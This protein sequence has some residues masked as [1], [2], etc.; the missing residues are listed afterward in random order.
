MKVKELLKEGSLSRHFKLGVDAGN[1]TV[2]DLKAI[3]ANGGF[4]GPTAKRMC[5]LIS[6]KPDIY[7]ITLSVDAWKNSTVNGT[8]NISSGKLF[9]GDICYCFSSGESSDENWEPFLKKTDYLNKYTDS[10][11][12]NKFLT[13]DTGGDGTC[14]VYVGMAPLRDLGE[15]DK[16]QKEKEKTLDRLDAVKAQLEDAVRGIKELEDY[17]AELDKKIIDLQGE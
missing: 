12:K 15:I 2:A 8:I 14:G 6:I 1:I 11:V 3:E 7:K 13:A 17:V 5:Q 16:L 4:F 10:S 9:V